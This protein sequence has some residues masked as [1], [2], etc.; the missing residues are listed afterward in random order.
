M[1]AHGCFGTARSLRCASVPHRIQGVI[2][3]WTELARQRS[4]VAQMRLKTTKL[5]IESYWPSKAQKASGE[6]W[7]ASGTG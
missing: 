4:L 6:F 5:Q 2:E 7:I 1:L 3:I